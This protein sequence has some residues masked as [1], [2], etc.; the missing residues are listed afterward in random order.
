MRKFLRD[1]VERVSASHSSSSSFP[2][3]E[4]ITGKSTGCS[5]T[6]VRQFKIVGEMLKA[7]LLEIG[8]IAKSR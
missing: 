4:G 5:V 8:A 3:N 2:R 6:S 7:R 1:E